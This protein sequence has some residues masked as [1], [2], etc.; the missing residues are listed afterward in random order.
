M[1]INFYNITGL[2]GINALATGKN[3]SVKA[4]LSTSAA[5]P[6]TS[7]TFFGGASVSSS[8]S[9][10]TGGGNSYALNG[11]TSYMST[12]G[13][14]N[15]VMG[16][17]DFTVEWFQYMTSQPAN[18]RVFSIGNYAT[19]TWAVSIE[20]GTFYHWEAGSFRFSYS[21][22]SGGY[23]NQWVHFAISRI[24]NT[25]KV[26]KNGTQIGSSYSDSNNI[27]NSSLAFTI[28]QETTPTAGSY[29]PGYITNFRVVKGLGVYTGNFTTPTSALTAVASANPYGGSNTQAIP[30]GYTQLLL[31]P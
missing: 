31:V 24:S 5:G 21:L 14:T 18:P 12:P 29:F 15:W 28:G 25:T 22:T 26:F 17:G 16:T 23:L 6:V 11:T 8:V 1:P 7:V 20:G 2:G 3:G 9:P 4:S 10:F 30:S 19:A 13:S 27:N